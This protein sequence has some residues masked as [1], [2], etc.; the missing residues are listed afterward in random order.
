MKHLSLLNWDCSGAHD[1]HHRSVVM[2]IAVAMTPFLRSCCFDSFTFL[3]NP[4]PLWHF[5]AFP[6]DFAC[7]CSVEEESLSLIVLLIHTLSF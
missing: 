5:A 4:T 7:F 1:F 6:I 2:M 3:A